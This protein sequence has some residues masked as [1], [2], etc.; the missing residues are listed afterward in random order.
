MP[1]GTDRP[2]AGAGEITPA[3]PPQAGPRPDRGAP[4]GVTA[5]PPPASAEAY[6]PLS[7]AAVAGFGASVLYCLFILVV[8]V[9]TYASSELFVLPFWTVLWPAAAVLV[10]WL[11]RRAI[12]DSEGTLSGER[13]AAWGLGL[14][15]VVGLGYWSYFA[16][17]FLA[18][19]QQAASFVEAKFIPALVKG[20][21]E[22]AYVLTY[23]PPRP[24]AGPGLRALIEEKLNPLPNI[25]DLGP[26]TKFTESEYVRLMVAAR[27]QTRVRLKQAG[28][29]GQ[30]KGTV[31]VPLTYRVDTPLKSFDLYVV[32]A[33]APGTKES[34]GRQWLVL[35]DLSGVLRD[36]AEW[37]EDGARLFEANEPNAREF[38]NSWVGKV[39]ASFDL[40]SAYL[41]TL[42]PARRAALEPKV[43][44]K[45][46]EELKKAGEKDPALRDYLAGLNEF[47]AGG[48]VRADKD[49]FWAAES[50]RKDIVDSVK[51]RFLA[52]YTARGWLAV[53][54]AVPTWAEDDKTIR[55]Y[56]DA[57]LFLLPTYVVGGR[58][59]VEAD[60]AVLTDPAAR[61][62]DAWRVVALQLV[63]GQAAPKAEEKPRGG[64]LMN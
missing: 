40:D 60:A 14:G 17:T 35:R 4:H 7:L 23:L 64:G 62:R 21:P 28:T 5:A 59:V 9:G 27:D 34:P 44:G 43:K 8:A 37:H 54:G 33:A 3:P 38:L 47:R 22:E 1:D 48:I 45:K 42:P 19:R 25:K 12:R 51:K 39:A 56:Y 50:H 31:R 36:S 32:A 55:F 16:A 18:L 61:G 63:R 15:V 30:E 11:A 46:D 20:S 13:L 58:L 6:R 2:G 29:P 57:N 24:A 10:C 26:F 49:S 52:S 41:D 53:S